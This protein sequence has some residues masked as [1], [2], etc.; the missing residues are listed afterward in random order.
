MPIAAGLHYFYHEGGGVSHPPVIFIHSAGGDHLSWPPEIRRMPGYRIYTLDLPGHGTT[1]GPGRQTVGDYA[2]SVVEFMDAAELSR[3]VFAGHAMGG[4]IALT[5]AL[6]HCDRT[7]GIA[8]ICSGP[9]LPVQTAILENA[10][11]AATLPL[12]VKLLQEISF[13]SQAQA[14]L[15]EAFSRRL[16]ACR[17]SL[18]LGDLVACDRF[19][20]T[21]RLSDVRSPTLVV[22][23]TEDK[24]T[25]PRFSEAL[26]SQIPGAALQTVDG[27]GHQLIL[28]QPRRLAKL[29]NIFLSTIPY[30]P[31]M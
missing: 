18:L 3:A 1:G 24:I 4:A 6:E 29:I 21:N 25:P 17:Q 27:A 30:G 15:K 10:A 20:A 2:G 12:A 23:G 5:L 26:A 14:D 28:E 9:R 7:A 16:L 31:G 8:L 13:G 19:D 11:A 22:S